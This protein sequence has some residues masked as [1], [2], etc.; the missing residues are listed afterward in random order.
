LGGNH[1]FQNKIKTWGFRLFAGA[2][3][4]RRNGIGFYVLG[5]L[6]LSMLYGGDEETGHD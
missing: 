6:G 2:G 5:P 4:D 3:G 1:G